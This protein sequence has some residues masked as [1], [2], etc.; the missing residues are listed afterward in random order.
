M[1]PRK[2]H[3]QRLRTLIVIS[4]VVVALTL[5]FFGYVVALTGLFLSSTAT[6]LLPCVCY[7][8]IFKNKWP[9]VFELGII[10]GIMVMGALISSIG[11]YTSLKQII[12]KLG[13]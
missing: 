1:S 3:D 6:T 9:S 11:T 10:A 13:A 7:L 4:T 5:P 12:H 2:V 8:K